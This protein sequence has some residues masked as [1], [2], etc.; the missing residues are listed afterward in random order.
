MHPR[1]SPDGTRVALWVDD[2]ESD[3]WMWSLERASLTRFTFD[4]ALD[5]FPAWTP[6]GRRLVFSSL[7]N[8]ARLN[9]FWQAADGTGTPAPVTQSNDIQFVSGVSPDGRWV[10]FAGGPSN[11]RDVAMAAL[12]PEARDGR[13]S[14][15][16]ALPRGSSAEVR[17][18]VQTRFDERN[19]I[20]SP[21]GRWL[22][23]ESD[24][25]GRLEVYVRPFPNTAE[26]QWLVSTA[27]GSQP[28]WARNGA[29]LFYVALDGTLMAVPVEV[30]STAW[31]AGAPAKILEARYFTGGFGSLTLGRTYDVSPDGRRF[32]MIKQG[33]AGSQTS[34]PPQII[35]VQ[36]WLEE[37]KRLVPT[38]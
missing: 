32:L 15:S 38:N 31:N 8:R 36:N 21:D 11:T 22:A 14:P 17:P 10:I 23:Y 12:T 37:L 30:R 16:S 5:N 7:R 24:A 4:P 9:T 1:I 25:A 26:G 13:S 27:G 6:D 19:G 2:Q 28:L 34:A 18:L 20:V 33:D 29:E 3:I 35:V